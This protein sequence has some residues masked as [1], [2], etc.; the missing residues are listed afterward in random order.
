[1]T[2]ISPTR[3]LP[4]LLGSAVA[5]GGI[6]QGLHWKRTAAAGDTAAMEEQLRLATEENAALKRE[7]ESLRSLAQG[8]GEFAVPQEFIARVEKE[9][10]LDF[11]STP[12][13]H[14][15]APEELRDRIGAAV[16]SRFGPAGI[17]DRQEAYTLLGCLDAR[18]VLLEETTAAL[19]VGARGWFDEITGEAWVTERFRIEDIPDQAALVRLLARILLHQHFP[20]PPAYPGDDADRARQALHQGTA[21]GAESRYLA[22]SAREAGFVPMKQDAEV[23]RTFASLSPFVRGLVLFPGTTGKGFADA[24]FVKGREP[25]LAAFRNPP[26]TTRGIMEPGAT[27]AAPEP[28]ELPPVLP[29]GA[30]E[31]D[32]LTETTGQL[33]L[34]LWLEAGE[35]GESARETAKH[36]SGDRYRLFPAGESALALIWDIEMDAAAAADTLEKLM[37]ARITAMAGT[38]PA[39][40]KDTPLATRDG[41]HLLLSRPSPTRLRF[42]NTADPATALK[43][44]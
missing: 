6:L 20:P 41:R 29:D 22:A 32:Y 12:V 39:A 37:L 28:P 21:T 3:L 2:G 40:V 7:N 27:T 24:L 15:I 11:L 25:L 26:Q 9:L 5:A 33:G 44:K 35:G 43:W 19:S 38:G 42:L 36:W 30:A 10:G 18:H 14:R 13:V 17:D 4:V 31:T 23:A 16:E 34:R 1:M 8:G